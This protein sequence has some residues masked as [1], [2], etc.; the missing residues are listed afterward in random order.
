MSEKALR[1]DLRETPRSLAAWLREETLEIGLRD[2]PRIPRPALLWPLF[3]V[4]EPLH[5]DLTNTI[6]QASPAHQIERSE[7]LT[8]RARPASGFFGRSK[9]R[10]ID[11]NPFIVTWLS[12]MLVSCQ[13]GME[14]INRSK[15]HSRNVANDSNSRLGKS[16]KRSDVHCDRCGRYVGT[17]YEFDFADRNRKP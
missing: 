2:C 11:R 5:D 10:K 14:K 13:H 8:A 9:R 6:A 3:R 1:R 12:I 4:R 17:Q 16:N 7:L 15:R